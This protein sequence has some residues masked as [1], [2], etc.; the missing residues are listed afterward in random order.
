[1]KTNGLL[2]AF[3]ALLVLCMTA[4]MAAAISVPSGQRT[5]NVVAEI[6]GSSEVLLVVQDVSADANITA[7]GEKAGWVSFGGSGAIV[8]H[9]SLTGIVPVKVSVPSDAQLGS[10]GVG[11][12]ADGSEI[13]RLVIS[14]TLSQD[15]I[16]ALQE[17]VKTLQELAD[18]SA[19]IDA[20]SGKISE[21]NRRI[22]STESSLQALAESQKGLES[23]K[24]ETKGLA[25]SIEDLKAKT[26]AGNMVTGMVL[27]GVSTSFAIGFVVGAIMLLV[28]SNRSKIRMPRRASL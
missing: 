24:E 5:I 9:P 3:A 17:D 14:T 2:P 22:N 16:E 27:G 15:A 10:Y 20:V 28:F 7:S 23:V 1:M 21:I 4:S 18:V 26:E 19:R 8:V 11:I 6:G 25:A 13:A 12:L